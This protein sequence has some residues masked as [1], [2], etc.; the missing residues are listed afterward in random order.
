MPACWVR[1]P[2]TGMETSMA[3]SRRPF[4][5][6]RNLNA[7]IAAVPMIVTVLVVFIGCTLWTVVY[8]FHILTVSANARFRQDKISI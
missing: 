4:A 1:H 7:K 8:F 3:G 5:P 6:L 2:V